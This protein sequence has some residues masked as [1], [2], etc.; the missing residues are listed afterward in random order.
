MAPRKHLEVTETQELTTEDWSERATRHDKVS[1]QFIV[2]EML[3]REGEI[4]F[5]GFAPEGFPYKS[6]PPPDCPLSCQPCHDQFVPLSARYIPKAVGLSMHDDETAASV[7]K[8]LLQTIEDDYVYIRTRITA[9]GNH[10]AKRWLKMSTAERRKILLATMPNMLADRCTEVK[11]IFED[12]NHASMAMDRNRS[13]PIP[14]LPL[15]GRV[16]DP[17]LVPFLDIKALSESKTRLLALL[18]HR[19]ETDQR[20]WITFDREAIREEFHSGSLKTAWNPKC[21]S[22][23]SNKYNFGDLVPWEREAAHRSH[24]IGY[25]LARQVFRSQ[26]K[27]SQ[28][29]RSVVDS[30]LD[31]S[32]DNMMEGTHLWDEMAQTSFS[33]ASRLIAKSPSSYQA[34]APAP[35]FDIEYLSRTVQNRHD[36]ALDETQLTHADPHYVQHML[37]QVEK[38]NTF[39]QLDGASR[40]RMLFMAPFRSFF[41]YLTWD[42]LQ[43]QV[44]VFPAAL[45]SQ[46]PSYNDP[47]PLPMVYAG[48]LVLLE[49]TLRLRMDGL[50]QELSRILTHHPSFR[51]YFQGSKLV[52]KPQTTFHE[53]PL[54]WVLNELAEKNYDEV[55]RPAAWCFSF[56]EDHLATA[57]RKERQRVDQRLYDHLADM[58]TMDEILTAVKLHPGYAT[59]RAVQVARFIDSINTTMNPHHAL[60]TNA[61]EACYESPAIHE[62]LQAFRS[63]PMTAAS[64]TLDKLKEHNALHDKLSDYWQAVHDFIIEYASNGQTEDKYRDLTVRKLAGFKELHHATRD[65]QQVAIE[66]AIAARGNVLL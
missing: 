58:A 16:E 53:D 36:A 56:F 28:V 14:P 2:R 57:D 59:I 8:D 44:E 11:F 47:A 41:R 40:Q 26:L 65:S 54:F 51:K 46:P 7:T 50:V 43:A 15:E 18:H 22:I 4:T 34:F 21:V 64:G 32:K 24:M 31:T 45:I 23:V 33:H 62:A 12:L 29:L 30:L 35:T 5:D 25:P 17:F 48:G 19:A 61:L 37:N 38:S 9:Y 63:V 6:S 20:N 27:I 10:I 49:T 39:K 60:F 13:Y 42:H 1:G 3:K 52:T 55:H 66:S